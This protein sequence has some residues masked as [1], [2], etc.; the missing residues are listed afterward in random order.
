[1]RRSDSAHT[2]PAPLFYCTDISS[3]PPDSSYD[4]RKLN[5]ALWFKLHNKNKIISVAR[6]GNKTGWLEK[7]ILHIMER[8]VN[9]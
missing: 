5:I 2:L 3:W 9:A 8:S 7:A 6:W 4:G 1:M